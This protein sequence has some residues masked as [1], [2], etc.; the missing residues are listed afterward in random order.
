MRWISSTNSTS[1]SFS[2]DKMAARSPAWVIAGP[3][4]SRNGTLI[5]W[6]M[7]IAKRG[8]AE[9]RGPGEQHVVR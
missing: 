8:L 3:L 4:V 7:I 6:A 1:P 9:P 2:P 5:S